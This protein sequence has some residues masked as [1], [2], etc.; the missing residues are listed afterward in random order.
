[1]VRLVTKSCGK[2]P[3]RP[4]GHRDRRRIHHP[5][6]PFEDRQTLTSG[7]AWSN[8][9]ATNGMDPIVTAAHLGAGLLPHVRWTYCQRRWPP[10]HRPRHALAFYR[11]IHGGDTGDDVAALQRALTDLGLYTSEVDGEYGAGTAAAVTLL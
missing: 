9:P 6:R 1:M 10:R 11:D 5:T 8:V 2:F 3:H 4:R 7:S